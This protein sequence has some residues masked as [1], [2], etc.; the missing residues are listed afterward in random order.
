M[1]KGDEG[2]AAMRCLHEVIMVS[3]MCLSDCM[4]CL[5]DYVYPGGMEPPLD[6][7]HPVPEGI[8]GWTDPD[9]R[10]YRFHVSI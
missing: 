2:G 7:T 3:T 6:D 10:T 8:Y 9:T 1:A 4:R 5:N